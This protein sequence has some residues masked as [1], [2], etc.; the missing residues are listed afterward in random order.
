MES[1][2]RYLERVCTAVLSTVEKISSDA[3]TEVERRMQR[4]LEQRPSD[5]AVG[6]ETTRVA[7]ANLAA[8]RLAAR[9]PVDARVVATDL[10]SGKSIVVYVAR[11]PGGRPT[12]E[13]HAQV[14]NYHGPL[15]RLAT[16]Q[17]GEEID[18]QLPRRP[19]EYHI[20]ESAQFEPSRD[21]G[22]LWDVLGLRA[23][24]ASGEELYAIGSLRAFLRN[25]GD[26]AAEFDISAALR[27]ATEREDSLLA[28]RLSRNKARRAVAVDVE[29]RDRALLD[30]FQD[31]IFR[32]PLASGLCVLGPPG[33]GK[34]TTLVHRCA[35]K[36]VWQHLTDEEQRHLVRLGFSED[37]KG[38]GSWVM[39]SP[40][41]LLTFYLQNAFN[42]LGVAAARANTQTWAGYSI[43][44][45]RALRLYKS[46]QTDGTF[47]RERKPLL[48]NEQSATLRAV[49]TDFDGFD[50]EQQ[51][52]RIRR[53]VDELAT[54]APRIPK[55]GLKAILAIETATGH[56]AW[57]R[58][59]H[60]RLPDIQQA[61]STA[62][63]FA[64]GE[65]D[66]SI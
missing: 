58:S 4:R 54:A 19:A 57:E 14:V 16:V 55:V 63:D 37:A 35:Q 18:I 10:D 5:D 34:S 7:E 66:D 44:L 43:E 22:G 32:L 65:V 51:W 47:L 42:N 24:R 17:A 9:Q 28:A 40:S 60:Q 20:D 64:K 49:W 13:N 30:R 41:E 21:G 53:A 31:E 50:R 38:R 1:K 39:F 2:T 6:Q 48:A 52:S 56:G 45:S 33:T 46:A 62:R 29:L 12:A 27:G 15:G 8:A 11:H 36:L 61:L 59:V 23:R 26:V 3:Q 25:A